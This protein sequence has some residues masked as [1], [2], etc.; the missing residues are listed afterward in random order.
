MVTVRAR[1]HAI[2][3]RG[4]DVKPP[5]NPALSTSNMQ[6]TSAQ[7]T[8][9]SKSSG[10]RFLCSEPTLLLRP[11][12]RPHPPAVASERVRSQIEGAAVMGMTMALHSELKYVNGKVEQSNF[13]DYQPIR[14]AD[15]PKVEVHI[16]PSSANPTGIGEPAVPPLAPALANALA[17][18]TGKRIRRLPIQTELLKA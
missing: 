11:E 14:I 16:V 1:A 9:S 5:E 13:H 3:L 2:G 6:T 7:A 8:R 15:M 12:L 18:A 17:S 10:L 4:N